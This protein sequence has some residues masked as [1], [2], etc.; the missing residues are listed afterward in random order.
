MSADYLTQ[1]YNM[2]RVWLQ[3][4]F[5]VVQVIVQKDRIIGPFIVIKLSTI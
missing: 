4:D 3:N 5:R 1:L 2:N